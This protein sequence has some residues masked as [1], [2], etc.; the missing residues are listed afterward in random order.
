MQ[1]ALVILENQVPR[2]LG[3]SVCC[4]TGAGLTAAYLRVKFSYEGITKHM[5]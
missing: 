3:K 5:T 4:G 1:F 2:P